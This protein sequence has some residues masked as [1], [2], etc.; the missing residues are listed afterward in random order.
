MVVSVGCSL[1]GGGMRKRSSF[2]VF[3][4]VLLILI[5]P[6]NVFPSYADF[7][8]KWV[9]LHG[10]F[11]WDTLGVST[12][13]EIIDLLAQVESLGNKYVYYIFLY[14]SPYAKDILRIKKDTHAIVVDLDILENK[15]EVILSSGLY[16][17]TKVWVP[18]HWLDNN[19]KR[20]KLKDY[21]K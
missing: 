13:K 15:A 18:I 21:I 6:G 9:V 5:L 7:K 16:K 3:L 19:D 4:I 10:P 17:G 14:R 12:S 2:I 1:K 8:G 20:P 11:C